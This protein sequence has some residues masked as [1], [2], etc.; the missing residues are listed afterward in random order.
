M[1][2][3]MCQ[4]TSTADPEA[5]LELVRA[6]VARAAAENAQ[7]AVFPEATMACFGTPLSPIAEKLDGPWATEVNSIAERSD[8]LVIA[9]MFTP[10]DGDRVYNTLLITGKGVHTG[11]D[12]IHLY[13]AFG[14]TESRTVAP[15]TDL[16]T[17]EV[18]GTTLGVATCYDLR[19]P[20]LFQAL[21][22][23]GATCVVVPASW[24]SGDGKR[25]QWELLARA[26]ALDS[27][28]WVLACGQADPAASGF[29][30]NPAIP[31]GIGHSLVADP[32]GRV[33]DQLAAGP[34]AL[35][36]EVDPGLAGKS[37]RAT[38]VL[39]NRRLN[40]H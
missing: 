15:G 19:F 35:V 13:D 24:G 10:A 25:E 11:Y 18:D 16:V 23:K 40:M 37:Q 33:H 12:K 17:T 38:A 5:N 2:I 28:T 20:E 4:I 32:F 8:V 1:R 21:A 39:A 29:E 22:D 9:G 14:F 7:V 3:A 26:R 36:T 27:G 34:G 6:G 31:T 30:V